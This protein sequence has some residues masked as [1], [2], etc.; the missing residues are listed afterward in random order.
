MLLRALC[1]SLL[2]PG[3]LALGLPIFLALQ[4]SERWA[5]GACRWFGLVPLS[6]CLA[7]YW[8]ALRSFLRSGGGTPAY[9]EAPKRLVADGPYRWLRNPMYVAVLLAIAG[10]TLLLAAPILLRYLIGTL[11][12]LL[13]LVHGIETPLLR[14]RYG[15]AYERYRRQVPCWIPLPRQVGADDADR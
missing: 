14:R 12:S 11:L 1:Y 8:A 10:E 13:I 5:L 15:A 2:V 7:L 4:S 6:A 9:Y 3:V